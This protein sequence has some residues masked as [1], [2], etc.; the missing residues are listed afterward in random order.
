MTIR[1][2]SP[3]MFAYMAWPRR[4]P[5]GDRR[6][7]RLERTLQPDPT[8]VACA[9]RRFVERKC[10][11]SSLINWLQSRTE[12]CKRRKP[13]RTVLWMDPCEMYGVPFE[14]TEVGPAAS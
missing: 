10:T 8:S 14:A 5:E 4:W 3:S 6:D 13:Y 9:G 1:F 7:R 2:L 11:G 12:E